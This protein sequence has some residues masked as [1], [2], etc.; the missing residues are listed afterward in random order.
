MPRQKII[1]NPGDQFKEWLVVKEIEPKQ[2]TKSK[3]RY[4]L[5]MC[6]RCNNTYEVAKTHLINK[7]GK[8]CCFQCA[9]EEKD[10]APYQIWKNWLTIK[11][12]EK[13]GNY[14][15]WQCE[16]LLCH[17]LYDL[18]YDNI[19][20]KTNTFSCTNCA[21]KQRGNKFPGE[22]YNTWQITKVI[23]NNLYKCKCLLCNTY[24]I[25]SNAQLY[26]KKICE[27]C[28][29]NTVGTTTTQQ[30]RNYISRTISPKIFM[31]DG[32][33]CKKCGD[34]SGGNL[35]AHHIYDFANYE[36][37]RLNKYN[38]ITLCSECHINDFHSIYYC[39][40]TNTLQD[41]EDWLGY[42]YEF[43]NE[44]MQEHNKYY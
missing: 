20:N 12:I 28:K 42:Q 23:E 10:L 38:F 7:K 13:K 14:R 2:H 17:Q 18:R 26:H 29:I 25:L 30:L 21:T 4:F 35:H 1:I 27:Y 41:L 11:E 44:L 16:C 9:I 8:N 39:N 22:V 43:R 15:Y 34:N 19:K 33:T 36:L 5:C 37:L 31:R 32:F 6:A 40:Q 3:S 24:Q